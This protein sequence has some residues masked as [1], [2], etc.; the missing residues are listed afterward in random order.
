MHAQKQVVMADLSLLGIAIGWGYTFI[1]TKDLLSEMTPLFFTGSRFLLAGLIL[2]AWQYRKWKTLSKQDWKAGI[3]AGV[4]LCLAYTLQIFGID[5]TTPG[6]AGMI[7]GLSVVMVPFLYYL[8]ARSPL[9]KGPVVGSIAAFSGLCLLSWDGTWAGMQQ[10]DLLVLA[11]AVFFAVHVVLV[12]R[13][14]QSDMPTDPMFFAM[15]QLIVVGVIDLGLALVFEPGPTP[16]SPYGWF[17]Y[18]FDLIV[19]TLL[20]YVV[21]LKAQLYTPPTHVSL[22]LSL[23]AL[24]AFFFSWLVWGEAMTQQAVWG[25]AL[26]LAGILVAEWKPGRQPYEKQE[27]R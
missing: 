27:V 11:C 14:Y 25:A 26:M 1:L 5:R 7:T 24:F 10:G 17:A 12:D 9:Q 21:Q 15:V 22:I 2:A 8:W 3:I 19:G 13:I 16:L 6:K 23:E 20:A 18:G 4:F